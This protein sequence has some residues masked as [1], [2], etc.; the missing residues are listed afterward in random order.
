MDAPDYHPYYLQGIEH[1]NE[2]DFYEAHEV[3]E[4]LWRA[5]TGPDRILYQGLIQ[6]AVGLYHLQRGNATGARSQ[7]AKSVVHLSG[8]QVNP[9]FIDTADLIS[10]LDRIRLDLQMRPVRIVRLK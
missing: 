2:C 6:A 4:D 7:L 10:Q 5:T 3:W 8:F 1:F 9:H